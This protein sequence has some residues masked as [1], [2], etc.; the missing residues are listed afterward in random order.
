[1]WGV[2]SGSGAAQSL[3]TPWTNDDIGAPLL[4]GSAS[5]I[6]GVFSIEAAGAISGSA[7][8]FHFVY[9]AMTGDGE[10]T[11]HIA[12]LTGPSVWSKAGVMMREALTPESRHASMF[13]SVSKGYAFQRRPE[14][15]GAS[16]STSG[17]SGVPPGWVRLV[18]S[19]DQF[20]AYRSDDGAAWTAIGSDTI[21][22]GS[23]IYV[24]LAVASRRN[25][26]TATAVIDSVEI[27]DSALPNAP[28]AVSLTSPSE[29]ASFTLPATIPMTATALDPEGRMAS[30][31]FYVGTTLIS[32]DTDAPYSATWLPAAAGTYSL[33]AVAH[34][35][36]G[37]SAT[38]GSITVLV[39]TA[40]TPPQLV[41][42]TASDDHD[43]NVSSYFFEVFVAGADPVTAVAIA[44]SD[45]GKPTP[46]VNDD[47]TVDRSA[48]FSAL[49]AG[50]YVATVTAVGPGGRTRSAP[51]SFTR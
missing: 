10:I 33:T 35:A 11:A 15:G 25:A 47:I 5:L 7:D 39:G 4:S 23:T 37:E 18:R 50:N 22:M 17:G 41:A 30:V 14:T 27:S 51:A 34:D 3:P 42:F 2:T 20:Q 24:G 1:M 6:N 16:L 31:D 45:L 19:G 48:F 28:P 49:A 21:P 12:S 32:R 36:D 29:G 46:D 38:S 26:T 8:Q 9:Q 44:S 43:T 40:A 13:V